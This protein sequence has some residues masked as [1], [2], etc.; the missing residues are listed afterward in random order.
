[1]LKLSGDE[2]TG[3]GEGEG[4]AEQDVG[5]VGADTHVEVSGGEGVARCLSQGEEF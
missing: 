1:M 2:G 3:E 5:C 4:D